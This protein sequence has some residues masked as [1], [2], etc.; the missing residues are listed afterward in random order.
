MLAPGEVPVYKRLPLE[1][2]SGDG[3]VVHTRDGRDLLDFYGG[4]AVALLG[5]RHPGLLAALARQAETLFFQTNL[6]DLAVRKDACLRLARFAPRGLDHVF[7]VNSGA[8][9]NENALRLAIRH[10][11]RTKVVCL[12]GG[13]HGRTA[14]AAAVTYDS[15]PWYGFPRTPFD[16]AR[17][18]H[19]DPKALE[20]A[21]DDATAAVIL[22]PVQGQ[23]GARAIAAGFLQA[24]RA[25]TAE[26]GA[27]LIADEVQCGMGRTGSRF[28]IEAA[29]VLPDLLTT[30]K[31]LAGGFPAGAVLMTEAIAQRIEPGHLGTT[32]GGGPLAAALIVAVLDALETP[33]FL[34]HVVAMGDLL[35]ATCRVGPVAAIQGR[36]LLTGLRTTRPSAEVLAALRDRGILAG[37]SGDPHVIRVMPPLIIA[38]EH[39]R[40]LARALAEIGA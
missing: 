26:R 3:V 16:V 38:E 25:L 6:V 19:D 23:I 7:L 34:E 24:A 39:V 37:G 36:G 14:A 35:R 11:G 12:E 17:V 30:A 8:E 2:V 5:Y 20:S 4:H 10:T 29:G 31:G 1:V 18:Q 28:A 40:A 13:W 33:G 22:E 21:I 9:A 27:L 15:A 32:F